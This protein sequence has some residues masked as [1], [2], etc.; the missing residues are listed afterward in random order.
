[1]LAIGEIRTGLV[2]NSTSVPANLTVRALALL[3]GEL[4]RSS[5]RPIAYA[6]SPDRLTGLD[7]RLATPTRVRTRGV[8]TAVSRAAITGGRVLQASTHTVLVAAGSDRRLPWAHYLARPGIIE[9]AGRARFADLA[10]GYL[11]PPQP[12]TLDLAALNERILDDIVVRPELDRRPPFRVARTTL[13][14]VAE[15][16]DEPPGARVRGAP[17]PAEDEPEAQFWLASG[18][19]RTA[20]LSLPASQLS[21][22]VELCEDLALHDW[23]LTTVTGLIERSRP[24]AAA[25]SAASTAAVARM[26]PA[27]DHLLHLWMPAARV[28]RRLL[29]LWESLERRPGFTR[30]WNV[31]VNRIR[32]QIAVTTVGLL[33][34]VAEGVARA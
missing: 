32:D 34:V 6:V 31:S 9:V 23:L 2:Q 14:W 25:T 29:P 3:P 11:G 4:V 1:M 8:G 19:L 10:D 16:A 27:V 21:T 22:V 24:D 33:G 18:T 20:R 15:I 17:A 28:D 30:Q 26:R 7:C 5:E 12:A 13:R